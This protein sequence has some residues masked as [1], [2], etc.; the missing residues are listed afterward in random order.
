MLLTDVIERADVRMIEA[1][2]RS[3][4]A[5]EPLRNADSKHV[6]RENL[7]RDRAI[8]PRVARLVDLAHA[9]RAERREDFVGAEAVPGASV[10]GRAGII[11]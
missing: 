6:R 1:R 5:L 11:R 9:A 7:D 10:I 4:F 2:D 3:R 8:E